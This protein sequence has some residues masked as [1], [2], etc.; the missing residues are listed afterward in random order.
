MRPMPGRSRLKLVG[1][2]D[3]ATAQS[4]TSAP[5]IPTGTLIQKTA[6]QS[7]RST[8]TPPST[9]P[10]ASASAE[11]PAQMPIAVPSS[12]RGKAAT[13][14]DSV[15]GFISAPADPLAG[16]ERDQPLDRR[17]QRARDGHRREDREA[18]Q[19]H[20][21]A[22]EAVAQLAA[23]HD[24]H[25]EREH[26]GVDRPL[27]RRRRRRRAA[28][29]IDGSATLT[30]VLSSMIRKRPKHIAASVSHLCPWARDVIAPPRRSGDRTDPT[31][32]G[33]APGSRRWARAAAARG[34]PRWRT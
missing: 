5:T 32:P 8:R 31:A 30:I 4:V 6:D 23:E 2:R 13:M 20:P 9:G 16:A 22:P 33:S 26:V 28:R 1:S 12:L 15:S 34:R 10:M 27:E 3:S 18:D 11:M 19:E 25:G 7:T 14:I 17:R 24:Q 29:W 21:L